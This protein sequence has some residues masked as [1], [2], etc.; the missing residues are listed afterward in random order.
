MGT[1]VHVPASYQFV[2]QPLRSEGAKHPAHTAP[3][4]PN[5]TAGPEAVE[6][7][8]PAQGWPGPSHPGRP[9]VSCWSPSN[10][11]PSQAGGQGRRAA[12]GRRERSNRVTG[13]GPWPTLG[14]LSS[15]GEHILLHNKPVQDMAQSLW[16]SEDSRS[17]FLGKALS[18]S[19]LETRMRPPLWGCGPP[20]GL[21]K[22]WRLQGSLG[23]HKVTV[24]LA[25]RGRGRG[26]GCWAM[27][28]HVLRCRQRPGCHPALRH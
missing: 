24:T 8:L 28:E 9:C 17:C 19:K 6:W 4:S 25:A 1:S 23:P 2:L 13:G 16:A 15:P 11:P 20:P 14:T 12:R 10:V 7:P 21:A 3:S 18:L 26:G 27:L 5:H 22:P